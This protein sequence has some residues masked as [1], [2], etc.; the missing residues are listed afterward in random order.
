MHS[1]TDIRVGTPTYG[2][3]EHDDAPAERA[4]KA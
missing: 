1:A 2:M 3:S 4:E